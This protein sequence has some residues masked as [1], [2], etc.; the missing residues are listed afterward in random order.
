[1]TWVLQQN[2]MNEFAEINLDDGRLQPKL[3]RLQQSDQVYVDEI[4][5]YI[6]IAWVAT[7]QS[8]WYYKY[9]GGHHWY[10]ITCELA[11]VLADCRLQ[12]V[13]EARMRSNEPIRWGQK[14]YEIELGKY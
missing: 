14:I 7:C 3:L 4:L 11:T 2:L 1:M 6:A 8:G 10:L 12:E 9:N 13:R 5:N